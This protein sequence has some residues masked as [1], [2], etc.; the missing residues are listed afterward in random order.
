MNSKSP[1]VSIIIPVYNRAKLILETLDSIIAQQYKNWECIIVDD[2]STDNSKEII[3]Q[4]VNR[5]KRFKLFDRAD[6]FNKGACGARNYGMTLASGEFLQLF[7]SDDLMFPEFLSKRINIFTNYPE[8]QSLIGRFI[9]FDGE[10]ILRE[11]KSFNTPFEHF[12][13]NVI[14]WNIPVWTISIMFRKKCLDECNE[15]YDESIAFND[16]YEFFSRIFI[17]HPHKV[18][19]L[20]EPLSYVRRNNKDAITTVFNEGKLESKK[21]EFLANNKIVRLLIKE[22]KF[23]KNLEAYFY[24]DFKKKISILIKLSFNDLVKKYQNLVE[25][26]LTHNNNSF[27]LARFRLGLILMKAIPIDNL[28]LS[29]RRPASIVFLQ[30]NAKRVYKVFFVKG[31][32]SE[33]TNFHQ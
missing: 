12:Y 2:E 4:Y 18:Y 20:D 17:K 25:L 16:D 28:F 27:L 33:K 14:T 9:F 8:Y 19:L 30:K 21:S 32:F 23:T 6:G 11:Q 22:G 7:D 10:K 26:I 15:K 5:D 29:Y 1:L 13:E 24:K 3:Q 31:Y